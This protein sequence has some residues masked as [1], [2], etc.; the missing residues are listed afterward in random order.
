MQN[1]FSESIKQK[2]KD[3]QMVLENL[4]WVEVTK[5]LDLTSEIGVNLGNVLIVTCKPLMSKEIFT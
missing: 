2:V 1:W 5:S 3:K 4:P